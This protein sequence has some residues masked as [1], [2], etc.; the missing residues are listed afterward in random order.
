M[1]WLLDSGSA[2]C[3]ASRNDSKGSLDQ[4]VG[5][6]DQRERYGEAER[7]GGA[8]IDHELEL[9]GLLHR[10][11]PRLLA[12]ENAAAIDADQSIRV[13]KAAAV[14]HEPAGGGELGQRVDRGQRT[15]RRKL[16]ELLAAAVEQRIGADHQSGDL[17][18]RQR[19][20]N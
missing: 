7:R 20:K 19:C 14:A 17:L 10:Q 18:R 5:T 8:Q 13:G 16:R 12:L 1:P 9:R 11:V 6:G 3:A 15:I 2:G 4:L